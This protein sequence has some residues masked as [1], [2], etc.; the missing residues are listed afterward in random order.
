M[1]FKLNRKKAVFFGLKTEVQKDCK[2]IIK[3][4]HSITNLSPQ[5]DYGSF[6]D[7]VGRQVNLSNYFEEI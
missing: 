4:C 3:F 7:I 5:G 1:L 6:I 2:L